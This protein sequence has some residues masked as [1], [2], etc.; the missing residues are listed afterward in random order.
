MKVINQ[1]N[2]SYHVTDNGEAVERPSTLPRVIS[3]IPYGEIF[4]EQQSGGW[5]SP[6]LFNAKELDSE[7]GL[8]YYGARYLDPTSAAWLSVDP[9]WEKYVGMSPYGYCAGNP[10]RLVDVDGESTKVTEN[11]DG[12]YT[13][14]GG[15]KEDNDNGIYCGKQL[16]GYSATPES[17]YNSEED[18]WM[19]TIN[20]KDNSG[21]NFLNDVIQN[22]NMTLADYIS[23]AKGYEPYD[24][25]RTNGTKNVIYTKSQDYYRGMPVNLK[26]DDKSL[27]VYAS[28]RDIG[29]IG[30][31]IIAGS[32]GISWTVSRIAFDALESHQHGFDKWHHE[33]GSTQYGERLGYR[34]GSDLLQL[35]RYY[36]LRRLPS[37]GNMLKPNVLNK[38]IKRTDYTPVK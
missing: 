30:A 13:V 38:I 8:Y 33:G 14:I 24:F 12:T 17:F 2:V 26:G 5:Q 31:G 1:I 25:K 28:A 10:V 21:R 19:G 20:P 34:I 16:I 37:Y 4:V 36:N 18:E 35:K 32:R 27:P 29:N 22:K 6:Y 9:L 7:T 15:N 3:Y 23:N 11:E